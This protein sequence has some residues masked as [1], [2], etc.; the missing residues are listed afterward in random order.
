MGLKRHVDMKN[1][2]LSSAEPYQLSGAGEEQRFCGEGGE[3]SGAE[4]LCRTH[5]PNYSHPRHPDR[6]KLE[7]NFTKVVN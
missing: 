4:R 7:T 2:N 1:V 5:G 3:S 6:W